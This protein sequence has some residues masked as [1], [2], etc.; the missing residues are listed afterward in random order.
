MNP[1]S[2]AM[3]LFAMGVMLYMV[4]TGRRPMGSREANTLTYNCYE[5]WE[6][7]HMKVCSSW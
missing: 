3:D 6:Y 4:I 7:P 5:A 1:H 2:T